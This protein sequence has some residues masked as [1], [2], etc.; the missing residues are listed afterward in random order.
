M[1]FEKAVELVLEHEGVLSDHSADPGGLTKYGISQRSYPHLDIASL[2]VDDAK[3]IYRKDYWD[4]VKGDLLPEGM[5]TLVFDSAVNQGPVRAIKFMQHALG[6]DP[7][8]IIGPRTLAAAKRANLHTF[9]V[10]FGVERA[11]HYAKLP[12]FPIFGKGWMR[13]LFDVTIKVIHGS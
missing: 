11:M 13:R 9:A 2:T 12:T 6:V 5:S 4:R 1:S 7:D 3:A 10:K 8:G